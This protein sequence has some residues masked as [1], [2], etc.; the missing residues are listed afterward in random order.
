MFT[1]WTYGSSAAQADAVQTSAPQLPPGDLPALNSPLF[2]ENRPPWQPTIRARR[3]HSEKQK[4]WQAELIRGLQDS[5]NPDAL[6]LADKLTRCRQS[7][8]RLQA[9]GGRPDLRDVLSKRRYRCE[10]HAC[11]SCRRS[12]IRAYATKEAK[13]FDGADNHF[14][15][16]VT[17]ADAVTGD[18]SEVR[19]RI[20]DIRRSLRD[21]RDKTTKRHSGWASVEIVG[22]AEL[23]PYWASDIPHLPPD[24]RVLIPTLPVLAHA[25]DGDV[26]WVLRVHLAVRHP[27]ISRGELAKELSCQWPGTGRVHVASFHEHQPA[28]ENA[29]SVL[30]YGIK[31]AQRSDV[32]PPS[33]RWP[34]SW[35]VSYWTW[36][37]AMRRGLQPLCI[38][39]GPRQPPP[40]RA[41]APPR[42]AARQPMTAQLIAGAEV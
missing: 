33:K 36:L 14:C 26:L 1:F 37:H 11:W 34:L 12:E 10:H 2:G 9:W 19:Q 5:G 39:F 40:K 32:G 38:A 41:S 30:S 25:G 13:R 17:V 22:H 28:R 27:G 29:K 20:K 42:L 15:S 3:S 18:L 7:R 16:L 6:H 4:A 31:H 8:E 23:D 21:R 35:Q 24:Q